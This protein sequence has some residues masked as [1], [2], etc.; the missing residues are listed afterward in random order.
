MILAGVGA[1]VEWIMNDFLLE[2]NKNKRLLMDGLNLLSSLPKPSISCCFFDPQYRQVLD[3]M[4]YGNEGERQKERAILPQM[5]DNVIEA[6]IDGIVEVLLP[7]GYLFF[8]A[9]KFI[10][11]EGRHLDLFGKHTEMS[12]PDL[13][14]VDL[15]T[16]DKGRIGMGYRSRRKNEMLLVYQKVPKTTKNWTDKGIPDTFTEKIDSPRKGHAHKKP[17][18]MTQR[19]IR[20]VTKEGDFVLDPCAGSFSTLT[21]CQATN[22]NF[23]GCDISARYGKEIPE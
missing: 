16:W 20:S 12:K 6:F 8:W 22:R 13:F 9:D 11:A 2:K 4:N 10:V 21:V 23:I 1:L 7:S 5:D 19:L 3:K 18:L 15:L 14:L 17:I